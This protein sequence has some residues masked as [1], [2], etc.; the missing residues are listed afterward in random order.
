MKVLSFS[1]SDET[2]LKYVLPALL[3]GVETNWKEGKNQTIRPAFKYVKV[4]DTGYEAIREK[5]PRFKVGETVRL[6]WKSR[7]SPKGSWFCKFCGQIVEP[8]TLIS[9]FGTCE[10]CY[11]KKSDAVID[12][13]K[14]TG[15][16]EKIVPVFPKILGYGKIVEVSKINFVKL[17]NGVFMGSPEGFPTENYLYSESLMN[18]AKRDGNWDAETMFKWFD[19]YGLEQP[20]P[21]TVYRWEGIN[22]T[23]P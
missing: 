20:K 4:L 2:Y 9:G 18:L 1:G 6:E 8:K 23:E 13:I 15:I 22:G 7:N 17:E 19:R 14:V 10:M 11:P 21:F 5:Q 3:K 16:P 12:G